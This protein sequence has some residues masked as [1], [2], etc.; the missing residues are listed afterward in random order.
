MYKKILSGLIIICLWFCMPAFSQ[1]L[2]NQHAG[3][4]LVDHAFTAELPV[5]VTVEDTSSNETDRTQEPVTS[6]VPLPRNAAVTNVHSLILMDEQDREVPTQFRVLSRWHGPA[7][8]ETLPIRW[9]LIDFQADIP[10][11]G[12][13]SY[14]LDTGVY[15]QQIHD[16]ISI[17]EQEN[18]LTIDTGA[19]RFI[20][21]KQ[22]FNLFDKVWTQNGSLLVDQQ[23]KGGVLLVDDQGKRFTSLHSPPEIFE[24]EEHGPL[25]AVVRIRGVLR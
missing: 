11:G 14:R 1:E 6:G 24:V 23:G 2:L 10:A 15:Q 18:S 17:D 13:R 20:L 8:D 16:G 12:S 21:H 25:H 22:Y 19:A 5:H 3:R 7:D 9:V 4:L